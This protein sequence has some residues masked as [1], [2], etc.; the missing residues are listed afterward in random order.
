MTG[1]EVD[2]LCEEPAVKELL[3]QSRDK[4]LFEMLYSSGCRVSELASLTLDDFTDGYA[5]AV[6]TG[7][8][9]KDRRVYFEKDARAALS[10]Y[11]ADRKKRFGAAGCVREPARRKAYGRRHHLHSFPLLRP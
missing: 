2:K 11:L 6:V 9:S 5:S 1:A 4:A 10:A 3:W 8:G 7:K